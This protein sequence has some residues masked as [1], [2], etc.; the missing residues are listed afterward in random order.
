MMR[1]PACLMAM[2]AVAAATQVAAASERFVPTDPA[3]VVANVRQAMPDENLRT[4]LDAWRKDPGSDEAVTALASAFID[5]ARNA[6]EPMYFGR[7]EAV[8]AARAR[9]AGAG[10]KLRRLYAEVLQ[11]RHDF[12]GAESLLDPVIASAPR[13]EDARLLRASVRLVRGNFAGARSDC[14][15]LAVSGGE[16][17]SLG[18]ACLAEALA[19]SGQIER[20]QAVLASAGEGASDPSARAYLLVTRAEL[21]E[22][23]GDPDHAIAEYRAALTLAPKDDSIRAALAD[24]LAAHG[25]AAEAR[26]VLAVDKP[27]LALLVRSTALAHGSSSKQLAETPCTTEKPPCSP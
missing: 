19:G 22:R 25:L 5:H 4:L 24:A 14:A 9:K 3:F 26:A 10:A 2:L 1:G 7:A 16:A 8:L 11:Y 21:H 27:S 6:R 23:S 15:Q 18:F 20:A 12:A 13:D 17:A